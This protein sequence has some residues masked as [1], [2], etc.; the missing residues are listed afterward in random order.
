[1]CDDSGFY[2]GKELMDQKMDERKEQFDLLTLILGQSSCK[3]GL[4]VDW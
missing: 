1:V 2:D 4:N 3:L